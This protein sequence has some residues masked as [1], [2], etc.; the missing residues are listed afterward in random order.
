[1]DGYGAILHGILSKANAV[2]AYAP[3]IRLAEA[4]TSDISIGAK[5]DDLTNFLNSND[6]FP[7]FYLCDDTMADGSAPQEETAYFAASCRKHNINVHMDFCAKVGDDV[8]QDLKLVLDFFE[9]V[10]SEG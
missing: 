2:Y 7:V 9:R 3:K 5:E 8:T 10:D 6:V 4:N 1:M